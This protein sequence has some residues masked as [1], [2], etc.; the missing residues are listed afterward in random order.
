MVGLDPTFDAPVT[1]HF[2]PG[3]YGREIFMAAGNC[4]VGKIH[5][6]AHLNVL[7]EGHVVVVTEEG[8]EEFH[9]PRV[10]VST[11]GTKRAVHC[12]TNTRWLTCHPTEETDLEKIEAEVI[13][14]DYGTLDHFLLE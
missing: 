11:P 4:V 10:W 3:L 5:K 12:I 2:A 1:N 13:A 7:I 6:H 9:A 14:P 8:R